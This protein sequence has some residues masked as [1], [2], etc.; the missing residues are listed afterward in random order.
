[1][2]DKD[3]NSAEA[4]KEPNTIE[5]DP[6]ETPKARSAWSLRNVMLAAGAV[7]L[8][9]GGLAWANGGPHGHRFGPGM[10]GGFAEHR[11][12]RM[13]ES[14]DA[15]REQEDRLWTIID[16]ARADLRPVGREFRDTRDE[17]AKLL[18]APAI[19]RAAVEKLRADR[20]ATADTASKRATE[21]LLAAAEV[22]TPEQRAELAKR[23][24][25]RHGWRRGP[26]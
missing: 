20:I 16:D 17:I 19:D 12:E 6:A 23:L 13:L 24:E 4:P 7:L 15:T 11:L 22:L 21:A 18:A 3:N 5:H 25:D 26:E 8:V 14:V 10:M 2:N 1:M 9:G